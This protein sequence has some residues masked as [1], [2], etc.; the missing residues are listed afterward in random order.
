MKLPNQSPPVVRY[1]TSNLTLLSPE[2][3]EQQGMPLHHAANTSM[4]VAEGSNVTQSATCVGVGIFNH[5]ACLRLPVVGNVC[6]PIPL[7]VPNI[8]GS[9]CFRVCTKWGVP[10]GACVDIYASGRKVAGRCFGW[11]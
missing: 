4:T 6:V 7:N 8:N 2:G 9:A 10:T 11:C 3:A 5:R 1:T